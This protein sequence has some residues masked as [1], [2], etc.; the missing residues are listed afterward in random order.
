M[1]EKPTLTNFNYEIRDRSLIYFNDPKL[2]GFL[3]FCQD[4]ILLATVNE[5][6]S[7]TAFYIKTF[8]DVPFCQIFIEN[9]GKFD[10]LDGFPTAMHACTE[11]TSLLNELRSSGDFKE[12]VLNQ[13][14]FHISIVK[15][16]ASL[17]V[18][19]TYFQ[20]VDNLQILPLMVSE[21]LFGLLVFGS[22]ETL[23]NRSVIGQQ[24]GYAQLAAMQTANAISRVK[25]S[26]QVLSDQLQAVRTLVKVI[27]MRD[28]FL[29]G[30]SKRMAELSEMIA[31]NM[32]C[33]KN[34]IQQ[35]SWAASLHDIGKIGIPEKILQ[36]TEPLSD[37][38]WDIVKQ[39]AE[40]GADIMV[41]ASN[42]PEIAAVIRSHHEKFDGSGYPEGK[43]GKE[44]PLGSRILAVTDAFSAIT[45]GY[46]YHS[47][48]S[49]REAIQEINDRSGKDFDPLVVNELNK[50]YRD[51]QGYKL[52]RKI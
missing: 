40:L 5:I 45:D 22:V 41:K 7:L 46:V 19:S 29:A 51:L 38:E 49:I 6:A 25:L 33:P 30:H 52:V 28:K 21:K 24:L 47:A 48:R 31:K 13:A 44:I 8:L 35:I 9:E 10:F 15:S 1:I 32:G 43:K 14:A 37:E 34:E 17:P 27:E 12:A 20:D 11:F 26:D 18:L 4:V 3:D 39:H 2:Y 50:I 42:L 36:K 16:K 23:G